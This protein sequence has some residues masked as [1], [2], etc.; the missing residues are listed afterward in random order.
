MPIC[1]RVYMSSLLQVKIIKEL[2]IVPVFVRKLLYTWSQSPSFR[3]S[4]SAC[5]LLRYAVV[6]AAPR[7]PLMT[8]NS[9]P[10]MSMTTND[11]L[12]AGRAALC[13]LRSSRP[14][15]VREVAC[16]AGHGQ[17]LLFALSLSCCTLYLSSHSDVP[18]RNSTG[19]LVLSACN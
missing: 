11:L 6:A 2:E 13:R 12:V 14:H 8:I 17:Y 19:A 10:C 15:T 16:R 3:K 5:K 18:R 1:S 9:S 4:R 7:R